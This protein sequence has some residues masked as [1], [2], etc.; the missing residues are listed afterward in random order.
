MP[1]SKPI[2][3]AVPS[4]STVPSNRQPSSLHCARLGTRTRLD[5]QADA[6]KPRPDAGCVLSV[7]GSTPGGMTEPLDRAVDP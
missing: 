4:G 1:V 5:A 3:P 7:P 2:H 6:L